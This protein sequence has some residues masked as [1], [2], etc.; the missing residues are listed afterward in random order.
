MNSINKILRNV[1]FGGT[2]LKELAILQPNKAVSESVDTVIR[3]AK[4][5]PH[6]NWIIYLHWKNL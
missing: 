6:W 2:I 5:F 1:P 3:L 4:H